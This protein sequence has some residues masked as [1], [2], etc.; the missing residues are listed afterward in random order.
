MK[1]TIKKLTAA[2]MTVLM[3][4]ALLVTP[5]SAVSTKADSKEALYPITDP[6]IDFTFK[7]VDLFTEA[8]NAAA[9]MSEGWSSDDGKCYSDI[10]Y[11]ERGRQVYDLYV[12]KGLSKKKTQG[13]ILFIHGGAWTQGSKSNMSAGARTF[14]KKG[15]ITAT[16][17]YDLLPDSSG[18]AQVLGADVVSHG[19]GSKANANVNDVME[20]VD[21]CVKSIAK[22]TKKLG[23]KVD[24]LCLAGVSAGSHI[25]LLYAY[26]HAKESAIPIKCVFTL[27]APVAFYKDSFDN[28]SV[29]E[30]AEYASLIS[31]KKITEKDMKNPSKAKQKVLDSI[32]PV[33]F[34]NKNTVP[35][36]FGYAGKDKTIGTNHWNTIHPVL[37]KYGVKHDVIWFPNSDHTLLSDPG[38]MDQY[39]AKS[40]QWLKTF[41]GTHRVIT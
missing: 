21:L 13:V 1:K 22:K 7:A 16:M 4:A 33:S 8:L 30:T 28:M 26:G 24:A 31:G 10:A 11:G 29:A 23:Y 34:V 19:Q 18:V 39:L 32:S 25:S 12:P 38:V 36:F 6:L 2:L 40:T 20:D 37:K 41:M 27:T 3:M 35:T 5:A 9:G 14:A 17:S 15:Y